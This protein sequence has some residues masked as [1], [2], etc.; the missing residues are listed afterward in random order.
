[1]PGALDLICEHPLVPRAHAGL[2]AR[3]NLAALG[4]VTPQR[5]GLLVVQDPDAVGASHAQPRAARGATTT[6]TR[7]TTA[8]II[9]PPVITTGTSNAIFLGHLEWKLLF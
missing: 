7:T 2:A 1:V 8:I 3:L 5:V 4:H 6:A 9:I